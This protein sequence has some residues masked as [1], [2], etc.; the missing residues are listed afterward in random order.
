ML[1]VPSVKEKSYEHDDEFLEQ[2]VSG[3][4]S[5]R[6]D[7]RNSRWNEGNNLKEEKWRSILRLKSFTHQPW[8]SIAICLFFHWP[9]VMDGSSRSGLMTF[10]SII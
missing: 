1:G 3:Q 9:T 4:Q 7:R 8:P 6:A 2:S 5:S 10:P